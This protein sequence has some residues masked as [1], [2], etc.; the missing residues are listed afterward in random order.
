MKDRRTSKTK[1]A[2]RSAFLQLLEHKP[3]NQI[4]V[5]EI[6]READ[7]GRGTFYLHYKD[8]RDLS[9][10]LE[11]E[12]LRELEELYNAS[13]P[14]DTME[15]LIKLTET[16]TEYMESNRELFILL[17]RRE[18][19]AATFQKIKQFF[20]KKLILEDRRPFDEYKQTEAIFLVAGVVGV[21]EVWISEGMNKPRQLISKCLYEVLMKMD[22]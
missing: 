10:Q 22:I 3:L 18:Q 13:L 15:N 20:V 14:C 2:I 9:D 7:L 12:I 1:R 21:L 8:I 5:A 19:E 11:N 17:A 4:T 16:L 6:S